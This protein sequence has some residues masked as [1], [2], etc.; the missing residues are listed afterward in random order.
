ME[1]ITTPYLTKS[2]QVTITSSA[3]ITLAF[4]GWHS[5]G[6]HCVMKV[7][8]VNG[9]LYTIKFPSIQWITRDGSNTTIFRAT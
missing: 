3:A 6:Y 1:R 5:S 2:T 4:T 8:T 7:N 9:G